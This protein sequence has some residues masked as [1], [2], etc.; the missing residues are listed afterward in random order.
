MRTL[1][2]ASTYRHLNLGS[3]VHERP[4]GNIIF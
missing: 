2:L 1:Q 4:Q 3:Y